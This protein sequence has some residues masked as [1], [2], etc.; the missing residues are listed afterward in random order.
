MKTDHNYKHFTDKELEEKIK[1]LNESVMSSYT[2]VKPQA[3]SENRTKLR[4]E[5]TRIKTELRIRQEP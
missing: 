2:F 3:K 5:I 4:K 1:E